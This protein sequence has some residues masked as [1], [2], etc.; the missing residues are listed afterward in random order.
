A[1]TDTAG[2]GDP[3]AGEVLLR[4]EDDGPGLDDGE[5]TAARDRFWRSPRHSGVD[6][7]GLGLAIADELARAAGG[8]LGL[9][10]ARPHGLVVEFR[11]PVPGHR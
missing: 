9:R 1:V 6:G 4:I 5:L 10:A 2:A 7:S 8:T 3:D 11:L